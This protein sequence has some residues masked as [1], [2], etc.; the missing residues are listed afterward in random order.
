MT[1]TLREACGLKAD[2]LIHRFEVDLQALTKGDKY[3]QIY[4]SDLVTAQE[5]V[6]YRLTATLRVSGLGKKTGG[7]ENNGGKWSHII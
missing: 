2:P 1:S 3:P 6:Q 5:E 7:I 4:F